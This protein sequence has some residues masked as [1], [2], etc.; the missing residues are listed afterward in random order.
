MV[1]PAASFHANQT[2]FQLGEERQNP[3]AFQLLF[4]HHSAPF[5]NAMKLKH[6]LC[7]IQSDRRNLHR[8]RLFREGICSGYV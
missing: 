4:E 2:R 6:V 1:R 3:R 5:V 8:G 7:Q